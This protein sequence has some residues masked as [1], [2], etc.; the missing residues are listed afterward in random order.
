MKHLTSVVLA[1]SLVVS[2]A[3]CKK[4]EGGAAS[5]GKAAEGAAVK[6]PKVGNLSITVP[7]ETNVSDGMGE[8]NM[9]M[10]ED[11]GALTV[12][13]TKAPKTAEDA[14][15]DASMFSPKNLKNE[16]LGDGFA[17]S[18][19]NTGSMGANYFVDVYRTI[20]GKQVHCGTTAPKAEFAAAALAACKSIK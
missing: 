3:A 15:S 1:L 9:L 5:A 12:E 8:G 20:G 14:A 10:Q 7:A 2:A 16:K 17:L 18:Y 13:Y 6:L 11:L 4:G 19:E